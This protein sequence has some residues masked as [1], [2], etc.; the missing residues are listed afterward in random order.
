MTQRIYGKKLDKDLQQFIAE[1]SSLGFEEVQYAILDALLPL[2]F[3]KLYHGKFG[4]KILDLNNVLAGSKFKMF[5]IDE[6]NLGPQEYDHSS[7]SLF[8]QTCSPNF[9]KIAAEDKTFIVDKMCAQVGDE[10]AKIGYK[11]MFLADQTY[12]GKQTTPLNSQT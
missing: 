6:N 8:G 9:Q 5:K 7:L 12:D 2:V 3:Y 4:N 10:L 11:V 1:S